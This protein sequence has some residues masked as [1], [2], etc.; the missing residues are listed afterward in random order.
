MPSSGRFPRRSRR[1]FAGNPLRRDPFAARRTGASGASAAGRLEKGLCKFTFYVLFSHL[2]TNSIDNF[3]KF[4]YNTNTIQ[5]AAS[6][7]TKGL[8]IK[9]TKNTLRTLLALLLLLSLFLV[10]VSALP[11]VVSGSETA[12]TVDAVI[13]AASTES[14]IRFSADRAVRLKSFS[15]GGYAYTMYTLLPYGYAIL[16]DETGALMEACYEE[17]ALPPYPVAHLKDF[18]YGG[19]LNYFILENGV[20]HELYTQQSLT[21]ADLS[22]FAALDEQVRGTA[23]RLSCSGTLRTLDISPQSESA[24]YEVQTDY[25]ASLNDFGKNEEGTCTVIAAAI[26]FGYY[27]IYVNN[28]FVDTYYRQGNGT[29][30]AFHQLLNSYVY[31]SQPKGAIF[32]HE[33][34]NGLNRYLSSRN[35]AARLCSEYAA[36]NSAR[37]KILNELAGGRPVIASMKKSLGAEW[38]H[39]VVVYRAT[40]DS[41]NPLGTATL[42]MHCGWLD[43][44]PHCAFVASISWFYECGYLTCLNGHSGVWKDNGLYTHIRT[45]TV[46]GNA[47]TE[48]HSAHWNPLLGKCIRC[49]RTD[50]IAE[51]FG[52]QDGS[53]DIETRSASKEGA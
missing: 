38:N 52:G 15:T 41:A 46:C 44:E 13:N 25:F 12:G 34:A 11:A 35:V 17:S 22:S 16:C 3:A 5:Y 50:S 45:C 51:P 10:S 1:A 42:Q 40:F 6:K 21:A 26:L 20:F 24:V 8:Q 29:N 9:K 49:G 4:V 28:A 14:A 47:E 18:Y 48:A 31:G 30:D 2:F 33:A 23:L 7:A 37:T 32:I 19:P 36:N 53:F 43:D 39:S 27:D